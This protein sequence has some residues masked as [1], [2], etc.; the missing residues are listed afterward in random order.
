MLSRMLELLLKHGARVRQKDKLGL[1]AV[2]IAAANGNLEA[3]KVCNMCLV[4]NAEIST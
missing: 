3:L 4:Y 1:T 2:H